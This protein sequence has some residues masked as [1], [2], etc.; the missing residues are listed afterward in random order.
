MKA[1]VL[2]AGGD[3][4]DELPFA[5]MIRAVV[6]PVAAVQSLDGTPLLMVHGR[7]D[8]TVTPAQARRLFD[9]AREPKEIRWWDAGHRL[10]AEAIG[11][12]AGWLADRLGELGRRR[13]G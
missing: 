1:V 3:L 9:A 2:A 6:D 11:E 13:T 7:R 5:S 12:A 4:P 8:R 10:P